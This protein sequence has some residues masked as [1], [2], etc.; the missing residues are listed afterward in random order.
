MHLRQWYLNYRAGAPL[1][2]AGLVLLAGAAVVAVCVS[3][4]STPIK[5]PC[6]PKENEDKDE[7]DK[8]PVIIQPKE[9]PYLPSKM[10]LLGN[11]LDLASNA[12]CFHDWMAAQCIAHNGAFRLYLPGQSDMLVTAVPEHYEHVVKTQFHHFSKGQQQYDMFVDLMGHSVLLIEGERWR[13]HRRLLLR[14]LSARAL[15][16]HMTPLIQ[17]HTLLLQQVL[18][19]AVST[20]QPV[21]LYMLLHRFTFKAF[22]EMVFN[23]SLEG[24]DSELEHPFEQAFDAAQSIVAGR[25]QQPVWLWKLRRWLNIGQERKLREHLKLIDAFIMDIISV[26]IEKQRERQQDLQAGNPIEKTDQDLVSIVLECIAQDGD[27]VSPIDV[28]NIAVA[29]LGAGR[30]TSA[31][32]MSWLL[33]TLT[34]HP[35]VETQLRA[36]VLDKVPTLALDAS[37]VPTMDDVQGLVYLEA[38]IQ[39]LLR[40]HTPV[41]FTMR[42]CIRD[43][44]FPDGTFVSKGT[45]VGMCHFG[46][47]RRTEVWGPDAKEFKPERFIDPET[48]KLRHLPA[49]KLNAFSGGQRACVG[50]ALAMLEMKIVIATLVARF[51]LVPVPGQNVQYAMGITIGMR[52]SLMMNI[53]AVEANQTGQEAAAA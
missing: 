3:A 40:L 42:E 14:L 12:Q 27:M 2:S 31:D 24:I 36:E 48:G 26:A 11:M 15:R 18:M 49:A 16:D 8:D 28:R 44:V 32:T 41:P 29:A 38:T 19:K 46:T 20:N 6:N 52:T 25:L 13:Y 4:R 30:D 35:Q 53:E 5:L 37:Y 39:E 10:P 51:H 22:A 21:D 50:K 47:A 43:T 17:R 33:H 23:N 34:Q 45:T 9:V 7:E 1:R